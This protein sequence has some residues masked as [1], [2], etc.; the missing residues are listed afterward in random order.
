[1]VC[2]DFSRLRNTLEADFSA[3]RSKAIKFERFWTFTVQSLT[4]VTAT[5]SKWRHV[6]D[7]G[8]PYEFKNAYELLSDFFKEVDSILMEVQSK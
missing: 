6:G 2:F 1:M 8:V 5:G 7:L 4:K 3:I